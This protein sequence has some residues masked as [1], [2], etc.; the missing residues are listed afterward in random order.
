MLW[1]NASNTFVD[2]LHKDNHKQLHWMSDSGQLEF[3]ILS[4]VTPALVQT[5][6]LQLTGKPL[7]PPLWSLG[8]HQCRWNYMTQKEV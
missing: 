6:L 5:K 8:Y 7:L 2:V 3:F 1:A 4:S